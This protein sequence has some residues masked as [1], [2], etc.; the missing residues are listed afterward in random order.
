[1]MKTNLIFACLL[2]TCL[3]SA[4]QTATPTPIAANPDTEFTLAPGQSAAVADTDM[5]ITFHMVTGDDRCPSEVECAASGPVSVSLTVQQGDAAPTDV[6]L[7]TF[8]DHN[9]RAPSVPFEGL[10]NP[11]EVGA[12]RIQLVGVTPYPENPEIKIEPA[13]YRVSLLVSKP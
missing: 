1:M 5:T 13:E 9:G 6:L 11:A 3:V 10:T 2:L 4:C 7:Q 8:T 12:Y